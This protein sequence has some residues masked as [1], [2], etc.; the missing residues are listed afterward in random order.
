MRHT[1]TYSCMIKWLCF[2]KGQFLINHIFIS[3]SE[4]QKLKTAK[5]IMYYDI[6]YQ[7]FYKN[8]KSYTF[9]FAFFKDPL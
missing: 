1:L 9:I 8:E 6:V 7:T 5:K 2:R 4:L 3:L